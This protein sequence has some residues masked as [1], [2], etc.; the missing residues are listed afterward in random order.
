MDE[1]P[2]MT[3]L[4]HFKV[5]IQCK[6]CDLRRLFTGTCIWCPMIDSLQFIT[7]Y[8]DINTAEPVIYHHHLVPVIMSVL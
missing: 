4:G 6:A 8:V 5:W 1:Y 7:M 3:D 2:W